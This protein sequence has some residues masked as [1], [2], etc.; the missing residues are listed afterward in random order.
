MASLLPRA[1]RRVLG[2]SVCGLLLS[3][4]A[5]QAAPLPATEEV[6][7]LD[8]PGIGRNQLVVR[9]DDPSVLYWATTS[10]GVLRSTD[11]GRTWVPKNHG[12][13]NLATRV[14]A[15][16]PENPDHLMVAF[17]GHYFAQG[18]RPYRSLDG[19][20]SWEP[21]VVC[22]R[23]DGVENLRQQASA[24]RI[25]F[26]PTDTG[27]FYY[28]VNS[29]FI[30]CGGFYRSCDGGASYDRN[31]RCIASPEPRP[32]C[33]ASEPE[34]AN[35]ITSN[36]ASLLEVHMT[37][38]DLFGTTGLHPEECAL[39]TSHD[40][41]GSWSWEDVHDTTGTFV[42]PALQGPAGLFVYPMKLAPSDPDVRYA[43][44]APDA[45]RCSNGKAY[46]Q[47]D[48]CPQPLQVAQANVIAR[49]FGEMSGSI[50]CQGN[51]DCDSDPT[52]DRVWRPIFDASSQPGVVWMRNLLVH[53]TDPNRVFVGAGGSPSQLL[54]L[55]PSN[56]ADPSQTP[57]NA[58]VLFSDP[59]SYAIG[60]VQD[61]ANPDRILAVSGTRLHELSSSDGWQSWSHGV[62]SDL[63]LSFHV[64]DLARTRGS[65][66]PR[67]I[68]AT[69]SGVHVL[70]ELGA[71]RSLDSSG[72]QA[73]APAVS[74]TD[75]DRVYVKRS[76]AVA[77]GAEG[78]DGLV[79][80]DGAH[81]RREVMC[82]NVFHDLAVDP[83]DSGVL[84]AATGAGIRRQPNAHV[85][86]DVA[87]QDAVSLAWESYARALDGL[88]DD[89]VWS[90]SFDPSDA[91]GD[92]VYAGTRAGGLRES[93]DHGRTWG[94]ASVAVAPGWA[95]AVEDVRHVRLERALGL[96]ATSA[97]VLAR[98]AVG[99]P[100][101]QK[102]EGERL[103]RVALGAT[104]SA[105]GYAAGEHGLYQTR[106]RG[107]SWQSLELFPQPPYSAV[108]E[109]KSRDGRHHLWVP[110]WRAGL[111][112]IAT[113]MT[114]RPGSDTRS[115]VLEWTEPTGQ[116][117]QGYRLH[118]GT[119]PDALAGSGAT[120][121]RSPLELPGTTSA[122]LSGLELRAATHYA[123]LQAGEQG[124]TFGPAGL[125]LAIEF[126]YVFSP[127]VTV[128][129]L[130]PSCP[131]TNRLSWSPVPE[132]LGT[133]IYRSATG[134]DGPFD[135]LVDLSPG[136]TTHDDT[137]L[138]DGVTYWYYGTSL[139][140]ALETTGGPI[141]LGQ[142]E[143]DFDADG[144]PDCS[145][146]A[147]QDT[148]VFALPGEITGVVSNALEEIHWESAA[149]TA[150][151]GTV[152]DVL[153]GLVAELPVGSGQ[154]EVCH[155]AGSE[156]TSSADS[157]PLPAGS[158]FWYVVRGRN[159]CGPGT[160]G[161]ASNGEERTSGACP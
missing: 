51:N 101:R 55:T 98:A 100:W 159:A 57:W 69:S 75:P 49:W 158:C 152:Y 124:G 145:D 91:S 86:V 112:R 39:M 20:E 117:P 2:G 131:M 136:V 6:E 138:S 76:W 130:G 133:R 153:R 58:T 34:P 5:V 92:T 79:N 134:T 60:L 67:I 35:N 155:E 89:Y 122:T 110:D 9:P 53:P 29:Q 37:S 64:Y 120:E 154:A 23:E 107:A 93:F 125:P 28:L 25:L 126:G 151:E 113:T 132:S 85:P 97:G 83:L 73:Y 10:L 33:A 129:P 139:Y 141:A 149:A 45:T 74:P 142:A 42:D 15:I 38:G 14:I 81:K 102:L 21:T 71:A 144:V 61:P 18:D 43:G 104:G 143:S 96:A 11:G 84:Y 62:L 106:D 17:D 147:P 115:V 105:R 121:G 19:G 59:T 87:D 72:I 95:G 99:A 109:T 90:M 65:D 24:E 137:L 111:Y 146:C 26:D 116:V 70:D 1:R 94:P 22:E 4:W 108:L 31:P 30:S 88:G 47:M 54:L 52:P 16:H 157:D 3:A 66:G 41:G 161:A 127:R 56:P 27:R 160:Y 50:D 156:D 48:G 82:T 140:P 150:G 114:A 135:L 8:Q 148:T 103:S 36:D 123:V 118:Y 63:T 7:V 44:I 78:P 32:A 77:I 13:P 119:D 80:M 12:L 40:K 128:T 46:T 68:A